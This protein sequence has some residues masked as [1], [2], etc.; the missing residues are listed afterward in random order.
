MSFFLSGKSNNNNTVNKYIKITL[1]VVFTCVDCQI[2]KTTT[3]KTL[4]NG[5]CGS[6]N[7]VTPLKEQKNK[8]T[9]KKILI[10]RPFLL[11]SNNTDKT[12]DIRGMKSVV[13]QFNCSSC[14]SSLFPNMQVLKFI[15]FQEIILCGSQL[16]CVNRTA[17]IN[18]G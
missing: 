3:K 5:Q 16:V 6:L 4:Q 2:K 13:T 10:N 11:D 8:C 12:S 7:K 18:M 14:S 17:H 1:C 9:N 15:Y